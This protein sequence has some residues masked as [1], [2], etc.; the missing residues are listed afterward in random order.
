[1][2][3]QTNFDSFTRTDLSGNLIATTNVGSNQVED[4]SL[5]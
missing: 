2:Y 1:L 4:V 5:G 3:F